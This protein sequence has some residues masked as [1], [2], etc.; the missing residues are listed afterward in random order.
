MAG[1]SCKYTR[2]GDRVIGLRGMLKA[3]KNVCKFFMTDII[4][5]TFFY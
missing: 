1:Y 3:L 5:C 4:L 2:I